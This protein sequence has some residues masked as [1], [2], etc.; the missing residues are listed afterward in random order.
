MHFTRGQLQQLFNDFSTLKVMVVGDV[1]TDTY[2][3]GK[4]ERIS[5]EAPVPVVALQQKVD[6]LGGAANVALN[7]RSMGATPL[8]CSVIGKDAQGSEFLK[9]L[10]KEGITDKWILSDPDRISTTKYRIIG[11]KVQMLRVDHESDAD[12]DA[13]IEKSL[14]QKA[15][16]LI[17]TEKPGVIILQ[18]YN[19]GVLTPA[20][21]TGIIGLAKEQGIPVVVDPKKKN[22][23]TYR[24]VTL[25]KPNLKEIREGL[26]ITVD[27]SSKSSLQ[28]AASKL[29]DLLKADLVMIT[30][31][32]A[33]VFISN[34]SESNIVK[35]HVRSVADVSGA[36]DTVISVA[37]MCI[38]LGIPPLPM[39]E[40][41]NLAGGLVCEQVGV[42]P[43]DRYALLSE[44]SALLQQ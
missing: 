15:G 12:L 35:S 4:V 3:R 25:F 19:K 32:E 10:R 17:R 36:G 21:I 5:P 2:L 33:G 40:L 44:A 41:A 1:M 34:G 16:Q 9:L 31:S 27:P 43:V 11:N 30:L 37:A 42:V 23:E 18:D 6:M 7:I 38:A 14:L 28:E 13:E 24:T 39:A 22:F 26:R 29:H 20:I 8:L